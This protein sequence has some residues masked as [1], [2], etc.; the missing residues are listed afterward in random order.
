MANTDNLEHTQGGNNTVEDTGDGRITGY[1]EQI[2]D[3]VNKAI[4]AGE[5]EVGSNVDYTY[6]D[7]VY[8]PD[9]KVRLTFNF[10]DD[11]ITASIRDINNK[12]DQVNE[13]RSLQIPYVETLDD[14]NNC[15]QYVKQVD[16]TNALANQLIAMT[17]ITFIVANENKLVS[18]TIIA[19]PAIFTPVLCEAIEATETPL[20]VVSQFQV[21]YMAYIIGETSA[22]QITNLDFLMAGDNT[23]VH[24]NK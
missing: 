18:K 11:D 20:T 13:A 9:A 5:I 2:I 21:F 15:L 12:I 16:P 14:M 19:F 17:Y 1:E 8:D 3:T 10:T 4:E 24:S 23:A 22:P 7:F 6:I